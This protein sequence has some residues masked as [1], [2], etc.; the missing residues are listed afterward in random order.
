MFASCGITEHIRAVMAI[1]NLPNIEFIGRE[2]YKNGKPAPDCYLLA[3]KKMNLKAEEVVVFDDSVTG[4]EAG[5]SAGCRIIAINSK[6][7]GVDDL[8]IFMKIKNYKDLD[9]NKFLNL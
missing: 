8:N 5:I 3:L 6:D 7:V 2:D 1:D 9:L 4:I